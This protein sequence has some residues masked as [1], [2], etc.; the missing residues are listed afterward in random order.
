MGTVWRVLGPKRKKGGYLPIRVSVSAFHLQAGA[1]AA[2]VVVETVL[3]AFG[4][5]FPDELVNLEPQPDIQ[6]IREN[7]FD[8]FSGI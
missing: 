2:D 6:S 7:P 5:W 3:H 4:R 1:T 8:K